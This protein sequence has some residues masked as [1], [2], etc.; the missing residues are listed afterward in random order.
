MFFGQDLGV[1]TPSITSTS[2]SQ[3]FYCPCRWWTDLQWRPPNPPIQLISAHIATFLQ[4]TNSNPPRQAKRKLASGWRTVSEGRSRAWTVEGRQ[5]GIFACRF[6][7][8]VTEQPAV[9]PSTCRFQCDRLED[10]IYI[11]LYRLGTLE[12][13]QR[14]RLASHPFLFSL[15]HDPFAPSPSI[16]SPPRKRLTASGAPPSAILSRSYPAVRLHR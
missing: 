14:A 10:R 8:R 12:P 16:S 13:F 3:M 11:A 5:S 6:L 15:L 4:A 7:A 9:P 1:F 2:P